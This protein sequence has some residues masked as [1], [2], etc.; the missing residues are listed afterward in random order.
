MKRRSF[1]QVLAGA[2]GLTAAARALPDTGPPVPRVAK[3]EVVPPFALLHKSGPNPCHRI[4]YRMWRMPKFGDQ[5]FSSDFAR[6]DGSPIDPLSDRLCQSCAGRM[7]VVSRLHI[8]A[9]EPSN[10][11]R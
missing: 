7:G 8:V 4:A 10:G 1:L 9:V 5:V 2:L 11:L 3:L 6:L